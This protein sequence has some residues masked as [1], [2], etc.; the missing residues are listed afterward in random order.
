MDFL[1]SVLCHLQHILTE[2]NSKFKKDQE[3]DILFW[4]ISV[5]Q[6]SPIS[7]VINDVSINSQEFDEAGMRAFPYSQ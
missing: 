7:T 6:G 5:N 1:S 4:N 2:G 3:E